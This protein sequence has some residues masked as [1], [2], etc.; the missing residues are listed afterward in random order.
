MSQDIVALKNAVIFWCCH[1]I[2]ILPG[3]EEPR[4]VFQVNQG[5]VT[6]FCFSRAKFLLR[7][8]M[9]QGIVERKKTSLF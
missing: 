9:F 3:F 8:G 5:W 2:E 7:L 1:S 6:G 4:Q